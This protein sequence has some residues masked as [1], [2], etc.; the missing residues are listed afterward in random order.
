MQ[1]RTYDTTA[2]IYLYAGRH[3]RGPIQRYVW[4]GLPSSFVV[5]EDA[6]MAISFGTPAGTYFVSVTA[7][8]EWGSTGHSFTLTVTSFTPTEIP[9][10]P[11]NFVSNLH[12]APAGAKLVLAPGNYPN[13]SVGGGSAGV[14][15]KN[16]LTPGGTPIRIVAQN[17]ANPPCFNAPRGATSGG[18]Q[19]YQR[20]D[21]FEYW[22]CDFTAPQLIQFIKY[23][24]SPPRAS[25]PSGGSMSVVYS[26]LTGGD[27]TPR[28]QTSGSPLTGAAQYT[29]PAAHTSAGV[30][31][32]V[33]WCENVGF[34]GC[35]FYG[36]A[37]QFTVQ[38]SR[39]CF[40]LYC[41]YDMAGNDMIRAYNT[42]TPGANS[43]G[44]SALVRDAGPYWFGWNDMLGHVLSGGVDFSGNPAPNQY[45]EHP[46]YF[47]L[48]QQGRYG[49]HGQIFMRN[50]MHQ[51]RPPNMI[52]AGWR[53]YTQAFF[54]YGEALDRAENAQHTQ[55][56][57]TMWK[58]IVVK[59][60]SVMTAFG[61]GVAYHGTMRIVIK[62]N[63]MRRPD[64]EAGIG[65]G[66][67]R[68]NLLA[69]QGDTL[70]CED[71]RI[72]NNCMAS[73]ES[74]MSVVKQ[75]AYMSYTRPSIAAPG[76]NPAGQVRPAG[77]TD[78]VVG[79][80]NVPWTI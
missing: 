21:G 50:R 14:N 73:V 27:S 79:P 59:G 2:T 49:V 3:F 23:A 68:Q 26:H 20:S 63:L 66:I 75:K 46:D 25:L 56:P 44:R 7:H 45:V 33:D 35:R 53:T 34:V 43:A 57:D 15:G 61:C 71:L 19:T 67:L 28:T 77:W 17:I 72:S 42:A 52:G 74:H 78:P 70:N 31:A 11:A 62:D 76:L 36:S 12:A 18:N 4:T 9:C 10:T 51:V 64:A 37:R 38:D 54:L 40:S 65:P 39:F 32:S 47:Q 6:G 41:E 29:G 58:N 80:A 1:S 60:N 22:H 16:G 30:H 69:G 55:Y 13:N 24:T 8:N 5:D 48:N